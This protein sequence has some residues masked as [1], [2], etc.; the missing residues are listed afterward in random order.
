MF[1]STG[2]A[3]KKL[4]FSP[5]VKFKWRGLGSIETERMSRSRT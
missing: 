3:L 4:I 1:Y 2:M 5:S